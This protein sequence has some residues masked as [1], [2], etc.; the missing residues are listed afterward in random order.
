MR[1]AISNILIVVFTAIIIFS[2]YRLWN[3]FHEYRE[4]EKQYEQAASDYD[5]AIR[6]EAK[7]TKND[8][9]ERQLQKLYGGKYYC[10]LKYRRIPGRVAE[11]ERFFGS[12]YAK[13]LLH[14]GDPEY[15]AQEIRRQEKT[16]YKIIQK[17]K[18][19]EAEHRAK[20]KGD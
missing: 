4:G 8:A 19:A 12:D 17:R 16:A 14:N 10:L 2:G 11:C 7:Q 6:Y 15:I 1:R 20:R 9:L 13:A 3:I 5:G 18:D